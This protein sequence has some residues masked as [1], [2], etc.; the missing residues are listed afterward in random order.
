MGRSRKLTV[1]PEYRS[2]IMRYKAFHFRVKTLLG[3]LNRFLKFF[4]GNWGGG[5]ETFLKAG[6][7]MPNFLDGIERLSI[8]NII[9]LTIKPL[10]K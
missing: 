9:L 3:I 8:G 7:G 4:E 1:V 5:M 2:Y 10:H 6:R